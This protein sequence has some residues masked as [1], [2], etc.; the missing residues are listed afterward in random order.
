MLTG[1]R[2]YENDDLKVT[3]I[4]SEIGHEE[5]CH[6]SERK[7]PVVSKPVGAEK[8]HN[9]PVKNKKPFKKVTKHKS[10]SNPKRDK[11]KGGKQNKKR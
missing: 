1:R 9:I 11:K 2:T 6:L 4:T 8:K 7:A 5:E 3:V 10:R